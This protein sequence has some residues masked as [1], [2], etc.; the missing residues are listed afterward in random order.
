[1]LF[2]V[3]PCPA[4]SRASVDIGS[5]LTQRQAQLSVRLAHGGADA[6]SARTVDILT[7][8][9]AHCADV[10]KRTTTDKRGIKKPSAAWKALVHLKSMLSDG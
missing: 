7:R 9:E 2:T 3:M 6:E 8:L 4:T 10:A 5:M 1:M